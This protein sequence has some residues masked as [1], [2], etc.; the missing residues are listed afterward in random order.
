MEPDHPAALNGLGQINLMQRKY[1]DAEKYLLQA[2]PQAPAA[3]YGLARMYL[4]QGKFDQAEKWAQK[5][6]NSGQADEVA[7]QMLAAAKS[8]QLSDE[9]RASIEPPAPTSQPAS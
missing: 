1:D 2:S 5:L 8:K 7:K 4:L 3:W 9:L 6:V